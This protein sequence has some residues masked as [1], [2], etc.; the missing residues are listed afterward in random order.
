[1]PNDP[2]SKMQLRSMG[3][4]RSPSPFCA[5][6]GNATCEKGYVDPSIYYDWEGQIY[7]CVPCVSEMSEAIGLLNLL[8]TEHLKT[9]STGLAEENKVLKERVADCEQQLRNFT[10]VLASISKRADLSEP[11]SISILSD[12]DVQSKPE[13]SATDGKLTS[14][15]VVGGKDIEPVPSKSSKVPGP[16]NSSRP[17]RGDLSL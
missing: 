9:L 8:E 16:R 10:G 6:C 7:F 11:G 4:L 3:E 17:Q 14:G 15:S 5:V 2:S 12:Q 1:M 13:A